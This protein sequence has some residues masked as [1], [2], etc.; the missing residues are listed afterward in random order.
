MAVVS[1]LRVIHGKYS[2]GL[3]VK[4]LYTDGTESET[5]T[6]DLEDSYDELGLTSKT[7]TS[8]KEED[9]LAE[10]LSFYT[11]DAAQLDT[12]LFEYEVN[13]DKVTLGK[14]AEAPEDVD[15]AKGA[16]P[17]AVN[18]KTVSLGEYIITEDTKLIRIKKDDEFGIKYD[19]IDYEDLD[20]VTVPGANAIV[21]GID[22]DTNEVNAVYF[23]IDFGVKRAATNV[24]FVFVTEIHETKVG[25]NV[26]FDVAGYTL[27]G[28][29]FA[30][31]YCKED[32]DEDLSITKDNYTS[33]RGNVYDFV[34]KDD[35]IMSVESHED[36]DDLLA[37]YTSFS[38][39]G[40]DPD[41]TPY[42]MYLDKVLNNRIVLI[43][44]VAGTET[45]FL[46]DDVLVILDKSGNKYAVKD[47]IDIDK[48]ATDA[49][50]NPLCDKVA[51]VWTYK[52]DTNVEAIVIEFT[53]DYKD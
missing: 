45:V 22:E 41:P 24:N 4:L 49:E 12:V 33:L 53:D 52:E 46:A 10:I 43:D 21:V 35:M 28:K 34:V 8:E 13:G 27:N 26:A 25:D 47:L 48:F 50:D 15:Y 17:L 37:S 31:T 51:K 36:D 32:A 42:V 20:D 2:D 3:E 1:Y 5:L 23:D 6:V 11:E 18:R 9:A 38:N 40:A 7:K 44:E 19:V 14:L 30:A 39:D 29:P 16:Y